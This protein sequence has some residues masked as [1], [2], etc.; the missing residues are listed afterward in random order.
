MTHPLVL[1]ACT[2]NEANFRK[3]REQGDLIVQAGEL[4]TQTLKNGGHI[5]FCGNGGSAADA[6]HLAA[7]LVGRFIKERKA[8]AATALHANTSTVTAVGNDYS[9]DVI[10]SRQLEGLGKTGD[11]L[12]GLS[13]SGN[14]K[15]VIKAAE[16]AKAMGIKVI[17]LTGAKGGKLAEVSD[18]AL[19]VPSDKTP[20]IQEMHI[21]VG[22]LICAII[23]EAF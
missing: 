5:F 11:L 19:K 22:H 13:T 3:L 17:G 14:S 10:F 2:E 18:I 16:T 9:Y 8:L 20:R 12:I 15:N 23:D 6:Q 4:A 21:T 7:E 1:E